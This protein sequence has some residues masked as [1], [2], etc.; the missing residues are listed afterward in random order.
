MGDIYSSAELTL[1][2]AAGTNSS[3]GLPGVGR[4]R[5]HLGHDVRVGRLRFVTTY[6]WDM[7]EI[8][9]SVWS[10][11]AWTFQEG[12][13]SRRRLFFM[14]AR[15]IYICDN[16]REVYCDAEIG[17]KDRRLDSLGHLSDPLP[18]ESLGLSH[19]ENLLKEYTRRKLTF[20][21]DALNGI[22]GVLN[23]LSTAES[24]IFHTWGVTFGG[25]PLVIA[26][27]WFHYNP[28]RR[29]KA[30]PSWSPLGWEQVTNYYYNSA[31]VISPNFQ[32]IVWDSNE[33]IQLSKVNQNLFQKSGAESL[34]KSRC[35]GITAK[36][37]WIEV[38]YFSTRELLSISWSTPIGKKRPQKVYT[39]S[40]FYVRLP[41]DDGD[42]GDTVEMY[43]TEPPRWDLEPDRSSG[44]IRFSCAIIPQGHLKGRT[45]DEARTMIVIILQ[46]HGTHYERIGSFKYPSMFRDN[47]ILSRNKSGGLEMRSR[48]SSGHDY[49][50]EELARVFNKPMM[51]TFLLG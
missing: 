4:D 48:Q 27:A 15:L 34:D 28:C 19:A 17:F 38:R 5:K 40:G 16:N 32:V 49:G 30:I 10:S 31:P 2:A 43:A 44:L 14:E 33:F 47:G 35:L 3:Y 45:F 51:Q 37:G 41:D 21:S 22:V 50:D 8:Y 39:P 42:D 12:Y 46:S 24:P 11:R 36:L 9:H 25:P 7:D 6:A 29:R 23:T 20:D 18:F 1:I 26:L 13:M